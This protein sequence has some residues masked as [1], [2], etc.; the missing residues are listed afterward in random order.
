LV[1]V[2]KHLKYD[3]NSWKI[4]EKNLSV[5]LKSNKSGEN[6]YEGE[7]GKEDLGYIF[8]HL[9]KDFNNIHLE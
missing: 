8:K 4:K 9:S 2:I 6:F 1:E 3:L 7:L 5:I